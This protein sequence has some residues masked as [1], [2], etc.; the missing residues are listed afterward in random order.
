[1]ARTAA[2]LL[3]VLLAVGPAPARAEDEAAVVEDARATV[4]ELA[5][6][7]DFANLRGLL[8]RARGVVIVPQLFK[9]GFIIGGEAGRAVMLAHDMSSGSWSYPAFF[10]VGSASIGLQIGASETQLVLVV[11][12]DEGMEALLS[13]KVNVGADAS[14][15][16][17]P[18]GAAAKAAT[19]STRLEEDIYAYGKSEGLFAG[20]SLEGALLLPDEDANMAFYGEAATTR[21]VVQAGTVQNPAAD[22]LRELLAGVGK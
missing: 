17:G 11:M 10:T 8:G 16:A 13:D 5:N 9:A 12:T 6:D 7:P 2:A 3:A 20:V 18:I 14:V 15:A 4:H 19:T 22:A 1:M 21:E